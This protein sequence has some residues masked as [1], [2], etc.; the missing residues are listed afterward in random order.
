MRVNLL[1][2]GS[3]PPP[4]GGVSI[5]VERLVE[6]L[7]KINF[8]FEFID[9]KREKKTVLFS[10][11]FQSKL[12]HL[13]TSSTYFRFLLVLLCFFIRKKII[14]TFHG[15]LGRFGWFKNKLEE[16]SIRLAFIPILM[17]EDSYSR[18]KRI[19]G[20]SRFISAFIPPT[21]IIN[22]DPD[23]EL[24]VDTFVAKFKTTFCTN[25]F[26]VSFDKYGKEVY[27]ITDLI[28]LFSKK[29]NLGLIIS[30]PSGMYLKM[31]KR[32]NIVCPKNILIIPFDHDFN[33]VI[34]KSSCM[35][36]F[37]TTDGDS[38]SVK[39]TL[40]AGKPVIASNVVQRPKQVTVVN[41][42]ASLEEEIDSFTFEVIE[43]SENAFLDLY[44]LYLNNNL[45]TQ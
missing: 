18:A 22:F 36:R 15:N 1:I 32:E 41:D 33:A 28:T 43:F 7:K 38:L 27:R 37:T 8:D 39:E 34:K 13:H 30:D 17:N 16:I 10:K 2:I 31:I 4:I 24:K 35:I 26:N 9:L 21:K 14:F 23:F 20:N 45:K 42:I 25:A 40:L 5:H 44:N 3:V 11:V 19:N 12:I 6:N 29:N